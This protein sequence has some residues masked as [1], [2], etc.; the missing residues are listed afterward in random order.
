MVKSSPGFMPGSAIFFCITQ[1]GCGHV[2]TEESRG[3][4]EPLGAQNGSGYK[5]RRLIPGLFPPRI[6]QGINPKAE[7]ITKSAK[8]RKRQNFSTTGGA[9][10]C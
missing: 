2:G 9:E 5:W 8:R 3:S 1:T 6:H 10:K 7:L 4:H